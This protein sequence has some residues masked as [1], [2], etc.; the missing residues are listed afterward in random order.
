MV[1]HLLIA[2]HL[3]ADGMGTARYHGMLQG[4][5]E[6][7]PAPARLFQALVA[8][9]AV[10]QRLPDAVLP[11]LQWLE[12][13]PPPLIAAPPRRVGQ[14]VSAY[15]PNN[16]ADALSDPTDLSGIRTA[17]HIQ[18][19][20]Y[21]GAQPL[22][23]AWELP[24]GEGLEQAVIDVAQSLY[25]FGRGVDMAW[26]Q[27]DVLADDELHGALQRYSGVVHR[28]SGH[29]GAQYGLPC[30]LPGSLDSLIRRHR[31]PRLQTDGAVKKTRVLFTNQP[32]P[33][34]ATVSYAPERRLALYELRDRETNQ[35]WAWPVQHVVALTEQVRDAA[36]DRLRRAMP[37]SAEAIERCLIGRAADGSGAV[38][39]TQRVKLMPLPSI[40]SEHVDPAIRRML[41]EVPSGCP[42]AAADLDWAFSGLQQI[43]AE[44]GELSPWLLVRAEQSNM[45]THYVREARYWLS[46]T[47]VALP[48]SAARR[49]IEP[50][51]IQAEA[52]S[53]AE[54]QAEEDRAVVAVQHALRHAGVT[55]VAMQVRVQREPFAGRG[56]RAEDHGVGTRFAKERLWHVAIAFDR[57]V[58]GPLAIGDGRF[59]GLGVLAPEVA[60]RGFRGD[61]ATWTGE[62]NDGVIVL[63]AASDGE[64]RREPMQLARAMR[65]AVMARVQAAA[66]GRLNTYFS[67]H[68]SGSDAPDAKAT[69]HL[70]FHWD[71]PRSRWLVLAPHRLENRRAYAWELEHLAVLER[72]LEG[73]AELRAG[74]A[75]CL[76]VQR[77]PLMSD[78][79]LLIRAVEWES[80]TPYVV[81]RHRRMASASAALEAD[82]L[83]ECLRCRLPTPE[84]TV[85][86]ID[87]QPGHGL[88]GRL[89]L[90]FSAA[91]NGPLALGRSALLGGGL[92]AALER[93]T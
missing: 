56:K 26:A 65:R 86:S 41:V 78:D 61:S 7:P 42:I 9:V 70:A 59:V 75:G 50:S 33:R 49:R 29:G 37:E 81:A 6:W 28:P 38:P 45:Q 15:V 69:R 35:S 25:Q 90:R 74:A 32:K 47:P 46:V 13:L 36:A 12:G 30:P 18:P 54:R 31:A 93:Q 68:E 91:V 17:K 66:G 57:P 24:E 3:H 63:Q 11:A 44:T 16:D 14:A 5:P 2:V 79:P 23:Y 83:A 52:K 21:D 62:D 39:L 43:D 27:A 92:F 34:F 64:A 71:A 72:A 58:A 40:G 88:Q 4:A 1:R 82:V 48:V 55:A 20:L 60:A 19:S 67:G 87:S 84:V 80:V 89:Q 8:G 76:S 85:L 22:L 53:A 73:M 77:V 51:R 10:G